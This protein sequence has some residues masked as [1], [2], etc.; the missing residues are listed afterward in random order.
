MCACNVCWC[1]SECVY[2][3]MSQPY[4]DNIKAF[5]MLIVI[6]SY[7]IA[8]TPLLWMTVTNTI[9]FDGIIFAYI[10]MCCDSLPHCLKRCDANELFN[11]DNSVHWMHRLQFLCNDGVVNLMPIAH[12]A[13]TFLLLLRVCIRLLDCNNSTA[14]PFQLCLL[15]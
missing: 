3:C 14:V 10:A 6:S 9:H 13:F 1:V 2:V 7:T 8:P 5:S 12:W 4:K 11:V 15:H